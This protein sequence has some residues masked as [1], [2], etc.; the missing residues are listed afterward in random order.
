MGARFGGGARPG[1]LHEANGL[2]YMHRERARFRAGESALLGLNF[3]PADAEGFIIDVRDMPELRAVTTSPSGT[4]IGAFATLDRL[5]TIAPSVAPPGAA[6]PA[7]RLRLALLDAKVTIAGRGGSRTTVIERAAPAAYEL[8]TVI[9]VPPLRAGT[10]FADRRLVTHDRDAS[11]TLDVAAALRISVLG[12]FENV[13]IVVEL[14]GIR[15]RAAGAE[16]VLE[17]KR[18]DPGLFAEA[19]R[20][21]TLAIHA[22]DVRTSAAVRALTPLVMAVLREASAAARA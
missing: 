17:R 6:L 2:A 4:S 3:E 1:T 14:D 7:V 22:V 10:G 16:Q 11:F 12:N 13:R 15:R 20:A 9:D 8:P 18:F 19:A 21:T 5:A